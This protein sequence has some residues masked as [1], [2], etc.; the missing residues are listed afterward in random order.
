MEQFFHYRR[1]IRGEFTSNALVYVVVVGGSLATREPA[2]FTFCSSPS[3]SLELAVMTSISHPGEKPL[4][5]MTFH[6]GA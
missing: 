1:I 3:T 2:S 4:W 5:V 6:P